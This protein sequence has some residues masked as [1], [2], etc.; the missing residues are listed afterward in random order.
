VLEA[1][2][3]CL[4]TVGECSETV[5]SSFAFHSVKRGSTVETRAPR[6]T[7]SGR[8]TTSG[9]LLAIHFADTDSR[10]L[11]LGSVKQEHAMPHDSQH[12]TSETMKTR[13]QKA[14]DQFGA[15]HAEIPLARLFEIGTRA[16]TIL[17]STKRG[18]SKKSDEQLMSELETAFALHS[19]A[20][21]ASAG[22]PSSR[23][24]VRAATI[25]YR[26]LVKEIG[27]V[28]KAA[29]ELAK[30]H[31][32]KVRD[33]KPNL[34]GTPAEVLAAVRGFRVRLDDLGALFGDEPVLDE[35]KKL[36]DDAATWL[37]NVVARFQTSRQKRDDRKKRRQ[38]HAACEA[39]VKDVVRTLRVA[40]WKDPSTVASL[41]LSKGAGPRKPK[42]PSSTGTVATPATPV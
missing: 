36:L 15:S 1:V 35:W 30:Q 8:R 34:H 17:A 7:A 27:A 32:I 26:A 2:D 12:N 39:L 41:K 5:A 28:A 19:I 9:R 33:V 16:Q 23:E 21:E 37:T 4:E 31:G 13:C 40:H 11:L 38:A 18:S 10:A 14:L 3:T 42:Q 29:G 6:E 22:S 24:D 25:A 20:A